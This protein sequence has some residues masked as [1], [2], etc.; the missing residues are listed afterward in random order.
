[1]EAFGIHFS[2]NSGLTVEAV[3]GIVLVVAAEGLVKRRMGGYIVEI[4]AANGG[5]TMFEISDYVSLRR[6]AFGYVAGE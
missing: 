2:P 6:L 1:M 4:R 5:G 3:R